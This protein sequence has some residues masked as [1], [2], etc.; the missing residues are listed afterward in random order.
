VTVT[1]GGIISF[2]GEPPQVTV[3]PSSRRLPAVNDTTLSVEVQQG[4]EAIDSWNVT[5]TLVGDTNNEVWSY[6]AT[7]AGSAST[8]LN[9]TG[10]SDRT[11][12][13]TVHYTVDGVTVTKHYDI[14]ISD[15]YD[16]DRTLLGALA[17]LAKQSPAGNARGDFTMFLA[18][19]I[20]IFAVAGTASQIPSGEIAGLVGVFFLTGFAIIGW[21]GY[22]L[23]FVSAT[24]LLSIAAIR[25]GL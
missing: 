9:L 12:N 20:T 14:D 3:R 15:S 24:G 22:G 25:R 19:L 18:M 17:N 7:G 11:L 16:P 8:P 5:A 6:S 1:P 13:V 21:V 23:V 4:T 10:E 2:Q